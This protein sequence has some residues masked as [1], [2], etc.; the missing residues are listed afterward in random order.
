[1]DG[2][3]APFWAIYSLE[4]AVPVAPETPCD[5]IPLAKGARMLALFGA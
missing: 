2:T 1:M 3:S 4:A 5:T